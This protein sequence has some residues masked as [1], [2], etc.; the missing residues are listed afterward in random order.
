M[1]WGEDL[2]IVP[3]GGWFYIHPDTRFRFEADTLGQLEDRVAAHRRA[4][5]ITLGNPRADILE[6]TLGRL[7]RDQS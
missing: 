1:S 4:N 7:A 5:R 6:W 2:S 3:P